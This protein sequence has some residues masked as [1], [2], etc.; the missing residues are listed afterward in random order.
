[1]TPLEMK[2]HLLGTSL[3]VLSWGDGSIV[4]QGGE[5]LSEGLSFAE[6]TVVFVRRLGKTHHVGVGGDRLLVR[7]NWVGFLKFEGF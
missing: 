7:H 2:K 4:N 1:M 6:E 5:V 3:G